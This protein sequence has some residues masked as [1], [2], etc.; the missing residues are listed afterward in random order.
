MQPTFDFVEDA[1]MKKKRE[2][3]QMNFCSQMLIV[4]VD[5]IASKPACSDLAIPLK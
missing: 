1:M 2:G 5:A 3:K 4:R